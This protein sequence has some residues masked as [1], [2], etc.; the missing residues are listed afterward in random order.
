MGTI[1][2]KSKNIDLSDYRFIEENDSDKKEK[3]VLKYTENKFSVK[4]QAIRDME[5]PNKIFF[6]KNW[7]SYLKEDIY[8]DGYEKP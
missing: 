6:E 2:P 7:G 1:I 4:R 8:E 3:I 5:D